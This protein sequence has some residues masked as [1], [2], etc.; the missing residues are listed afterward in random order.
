MEVEGKTGQRK[1]LPVAEVRVQAGIRQE[2]GAA[3]RP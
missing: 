2:S 3:D 1:S